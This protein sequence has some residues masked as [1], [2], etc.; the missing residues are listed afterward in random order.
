M[1]YHNDMIMVLHIVYEMESP[2]N[3]HAIVI[4]HIYLFIILQ[5]VKYWYADNEHT[6]KFG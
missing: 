4:F 5:N 2:N 1:Y 3:V 6:Y